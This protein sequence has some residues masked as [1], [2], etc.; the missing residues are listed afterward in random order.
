MA[1][2]SGH[3]HKGGYARDARSGIHFRVL[4]AALETPPPDMTYALLEVYDDSLVVHGFGDCKSATY[5][6]DHQ[7][8]PETVTD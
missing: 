7:A 4:E 2:I 8:L 6:L 5:S 1:S 3:A